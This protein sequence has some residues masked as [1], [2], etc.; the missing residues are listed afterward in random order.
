MFMR[1]LVMWAILVL[2]AALLLSASVD[3]AFGQPGSVP[4]CI[5]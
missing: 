1:V 4:Q 3:V 5:A 2:W